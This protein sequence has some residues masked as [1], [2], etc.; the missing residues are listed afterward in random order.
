MGA[1]AVEMPGRNTREEFKA[2]V[3]LLRDW[4]IEVGEF[5][6]PTD[7]DERGW[8]HVWDTPAEAEKFAEELE[9]R[10]GLPNWTVRSIDNPSE[11]PRGPEI[12]VSME[13]TGTT[14]CRLSD[15]DLQRIRSV[16]PRSKVLHELSISRRHLKSMQS[17]HR[18]PWEQIAM[19]M[20]GLEVGDFFQIGGI[21]L[22]NSASGEI[23]WSDREPHNKSTSNGHASP[24]LNGE[25]RDTVGAED[26]STIFAHLVARTLGG[27]VF[28]PL[29]QDGYETVIEPWD[30]MSNRFLNG[31]LYQKAFELRAGCYL[32]L[33][34]LQTRYQIRIHKGSVLCGL[35]TTAIWN[36]DL[37][38]AKLSWLL[39][40]IEDTLTFPKT[41]F[42]LSNY[43][44]LIKIP[45]ESTSIEEFS[46]RIYSR[47]N[48]SQLMVT[49]PEIAF[50]LGFDPEVDSMNRSV[51]DRLAT[52]S[53]MLT[54]SFPE[55]PGGRSPTELL[56]NLWGS[57]TLPE[58]MNSEAG[59]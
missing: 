33:L 50:D 8:L 36:D 17:S 6:S 31:G 39:G 1:F 27:N 9:Q 30:R 47:L 32:C 26:F 59:K 55:L 53:A 29:P 4:G 13:P 42:E 43:N 12:L 22:V 35:G 25:G 45:L 49:A 5:E 52:L 37:R 14:V 34:S 23:L 10:T 57:L 2:Y 11:T 41:C 46:D 58:S 24:S 15:E 51:F 20:I 18:N 48:E 3:H 21:K 38:T 28:S 16:L 44:N 40:L 54:G 56:Q 7:G 19:L